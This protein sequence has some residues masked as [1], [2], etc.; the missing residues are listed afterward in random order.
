MLIGA[1]DNERHFALGFRLSAYVTIEGCYGHLSVLV[2]GDIMGEKRGTLRT[3]W[4]L[5]A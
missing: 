5:V 2:R 3:P 1:L 4:W